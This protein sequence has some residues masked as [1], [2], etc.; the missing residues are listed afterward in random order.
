MAYPGTIDAITFGQM[1]SFYTDS[2]TTTVRAAAG[3]IISAITFLE[4]TTFSALVSRDADLCVN[5]V[6]ASGQ[7]G[8]ILGS[9]QVFPR[10]VTIY[11]KWKEF[12]LYSGAVIAYQGV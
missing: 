4:E 1:G 5:T 10:G 12:S 9:D 6:T 2:T 3:K 11:G 7:N 8:E